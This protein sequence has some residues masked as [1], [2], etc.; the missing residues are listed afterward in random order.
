MRSVDKCVLPAP[1]GGNI[2]VSS[3]ANIHG[4]ISKII[5]LN[6]IIQEKFT[7][8]LLKIKLGNDTQLYT[9]FGGD[10]PINEL[11]TN[12]EAWVWYKHCKSPANS[13]PD[14]A[15]IWIFSVDPNDVNPN[16]KLGPH[17]N[18]GTYPFTIK[19]HT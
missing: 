14:A 12:Q 6:V 7:N 15:I 3:P 17:E 10:V 16:W 1:D 4:R 5:N 8:K 13:I 9:V 2:G 19:D 11:Q 18:T